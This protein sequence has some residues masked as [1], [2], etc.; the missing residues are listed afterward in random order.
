MVRPTLWFH[1]HTLHLKIPLHLIRP[2]NVSSFISFN[3]ALWCNFA[4]A[5]GIE[6]EADRL[7]SRALNSEQSNADASG[8]LGT[9][10][11]VAQRDGLHTDSQVSQ[12]FPLANQCALL[13]MLRRSRGSWSSRQ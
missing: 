3:A 1:H 11:T 6:G 4:V 2:A 7:S 9:P 10:P 8:V 5:V 13:P 12:F